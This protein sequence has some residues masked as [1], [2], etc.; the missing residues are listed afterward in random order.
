MGGFMQPQGHTQ[1][2]TGTVD[3]GLNPQAALDAPRW[4]VNGGLEVSV[5]VGTPE[6]VLNG[7]A[8]RG[9]NVELSYARADFGR[10]QIIWRLDEGVY[11]AG[12]DMRGDG[13]AVGW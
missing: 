10:G 1:V 5:E 3:Y 4:R 9:H 6:Y 2:V 7:L 13:A 11:V 8:M 12:S